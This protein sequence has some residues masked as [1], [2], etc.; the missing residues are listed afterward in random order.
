MWSQSN[1]FAIVVCTCNGERF[2]DE[3]L[4]S[5]REQDGVGEIVVSDD[6]STDGTL[7]ILLRH[8]EED[9]RILISRNPARLGVTANFQ[10]A[11]TLVRAPWVALS[12]QDDIWLPGKLARMRACWDGNSLLMHHASHKFRGLHAPRLASVRADERRKFRGTD[13]RRLLHRN[14]VVGHT[15]V[16]RADL[17]RQLMPFPRTLPHDWWLGLG[18][19]IRGSVQFLDE[20]LVHYRIHQSNAYHAAGSRGCR[21]SREELL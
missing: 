4:Q 17:A 21:T 10:H 3:Q 9:S 6:A 12:D 11:I 16:I 19:G 1:P 20:Y 5:L 2:V 7:A 18:A 13:W 15:V 8:A 14:S